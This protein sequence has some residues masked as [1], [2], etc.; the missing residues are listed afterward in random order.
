[1]EKQKLANRLKQLFEG[2]LSRLNY[3]KG[4]IGLAIPFLIIFGSYFVLQVLSTVFGIRLSD[5]GLLSFFYV[6]FGLLALVYFVIVGASIMVRR[7][8]DFNKPWTYLLFV[9]IGVSLLSLI[10]T[11]LAGLGHFI[12]ISLL[13]FLKGDQKNNNFGEPDKNRSIK[14]IVGLKN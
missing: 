6:V 4:I 9:F 13:L 1:M 7:F 2:R 12:F 8:H 3:F 14:Q 10:S 11:S 5:N